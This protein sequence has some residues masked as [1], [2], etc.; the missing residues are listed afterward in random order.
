MN[1]AAHNA[2]EPQQVQRREKK[3]RERRKQMLADFRDLLKMPQGRRVFWSLLDHCGVFRSIWNNSALIHFNEGKRDTGLFIMHE[4]ADADPNALIT[5]MTEA[6]AKELTE[7]LEDE[8][9][10]AQRHKTDLEE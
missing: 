1:F 9:T 10:A 4:I 7:R 8:N 5:M 2:S 6:N 3:A